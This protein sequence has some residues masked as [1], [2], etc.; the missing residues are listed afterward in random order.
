M[1]RQRRGAGNRFVGWRRAKS[2]GP[3]GREFR[4]AIEPLEQRCVLAATVVPYTSATVDPSDG[5]RLSVND[6]QPVVVA[7]EFATDG[8]FEGWTVAGANSSKVTGGL[9]TA[10]A[11]VVGTPVSLT[12]SAIASAPFL[13]YGFYDYI[14]LRMQ[15]PV[16]L[17]SDI[18]FNFSTSTQA[19]FSSARSFTIP[20]AQVA[21]DGQ[22]H[23]YRINVG[24]AVWWKDTLAGLQISIPTTTAGQSESIDY[25]EVG[26]LP[27]S[28]LAVA[29]LTKVQYPG[30]PLDPNNTVKVQTANIQSVQSKHFIF[31]Y[32]SVDAGANPGNFTN[33]ATVAHNELQILEQSVRIYTQV[34]GFKDVFSWAQNQ[35]GDSTRYKLNVTS[36]YAG[37]FS[38]GWWLNVDTSGG[39]NTTVNGNSLTETPGSP[40]PHEYGHVTDS[41]N[42]NYLAGGHFESH[43]NWYRE[44]WV[45]WYAPMF[46]AQGVTPSNYT[47]I[48]QQY[49]NLHV[50]NARLIYNDMR[51]YTPLQYY[52]DSMGL[53]PTLV[54]KLWS[55]GGTNLTIFN[56]LANLLPAG[57]SIKDVAAKLMAYWPTLDF[58]VRSSM[59]SAIF[60]S[61]SAQTAA[62]AQANF[63]YQSTSYLIPDADD[64]GYTVPLER[65]PEKYAYM[66][67][68]LVPS[69]GSTSVTVTV[70]GLPSTDS[71]ADWRYVLVDLANFG[72]TNP[73]VI[74]YSS[75]FANGAAATFN[76]AS[77]TDT[78]VLVVTATPSNTVLDLTSY[79]NTARSNQAS[80]RLTYPYQ[81]FVTGATPASGT[82]ARIAYPRS[83]SGSFHIN[84]DGSTGGWVD[85]SASVAATVYVAPGAEVLRNAIVSGSARIEDFAVV[86]DNARVSGSAIISGYAVV[87]GSA[88]ISGSA[89]VEDHAMVGSGGNVQGN[90]VVEQDAYL[91]AF[92]GQSVTVTNNAVVRGVATPTGGTLSGTA[93]IDYDYTSDFSLSNGVNDNNHPF[94]EPYG[95]YYS[96]TQAKPNGLIASYGINETSGNQL[97]DEFGALNAL[98]RGTPSRVA[99]ATMNAPVLSL[100]GSTQYAV[101]DRS[102]ADLADGTYSLWAN[103][104]SSTADQPLLYLGSSANTYLKLVARDANGFAHL[105]ISMNGTVQQLVS[106]VAVPL[107]SWTNIAI[108]FSG[109]QAKFYI[110]GA[111]AGTAA[112]SF[113]PTD[114]LTT[115]AFQMPTSLF[116]G[117]DASGNFFA[118][119]LTDIRFYNVALTQAE[120]KNEMARSGPRIGEFFATATMD[121]NGT[122]TM[123]ESGVHNGT[124]RTLQAWVYPRS[125]AAGYTAILDSYDERG[126][127]NN[128]GNGF[129]LSGGVI[130]VRLDGVGLWNTGV[131]V[132]LNKWQQITVTISNGLAI[133]YVNGVQRGSRTYSTSVTAA[134][135]YHIGFYQTDTTPT[136]TGFFNGQLYDVRV[137]NAAVA[138]TGKLD[139]PPVAVNDTPTVPGG[140]STPI[141]VLANDSDPN[142]IVTLT[143]SQVTQPQHGAVSIPLGGANVVYTPTSGYSGSDSFTYTATD[144]F[145]STA[146]A[147]VNLT[148]AISLASISISP[149]SAS[150]AGGDTQQFTATGYD[151]AGMPMNP[152]PTFTWSIV[153]GAGAVTPSGGTNAS[154]QF[155]AGSNTETVVIQV[156][157]G[158]VSST[159]NVNVTSSVAPAITNAANAS[160]T[161]VTG[162]TTNL[163]VL[164]A[165]A[166]GDGSLTYSWSTL[167]A[168]PAAVQFSASGT[169]GA[170]NTIA[171]FSKA[172]NYDFQVKVT[173]PSGFYATSN[174]SVQVVQTATGVSVSPASTAIA[175][176]TTKLFTASNLDQFGSVMPGTPSV[177]WSIVSGGGSINSACLFSAGRTAGPVTIRATAAGGAFGTAN[178]TV[179]YEELAWYQ[180][181]ASG[182][183]L[184]DS[185]GNGKTATLTGT[186]NTNYNFTVGV[187]GTALH[188][189]TAGTP[190]AEYATLP[191]GIVSTLN[192]FTIATW[193]KID[194]L[195]TW[196]RIFDFGTGTTAN[197][198]LTPRAN[199]VGGPLRFA[200]TTGGNGAEQQINGPTLSAGVWYH[201]A[202]TLSGTTATM[203]VNG[204]AVATNTSMSTTPAAMGNTNLNY[205]GKSQYGDPGFQGSIEDF[206]IFGRALSAT[207][208]LHLVYPTIV[209][210]PTAAAPNPVVTPT[211]NLSVFGADV[212]A[213]ESA[214]IYTSAVVGTPPAPV[215]FF[216]NGT[217]AAKNTIVTFTQPGTYNFQVTLVNPAAGFSTV[218]NTLSVIVGTIRYSGDFTLNSQLGADDLPAMLSALTDLTGFQAQHGLSNAEMLAIGDLN[219]D[220]RVSNA[221]I[222]SLLDRLIQAQG[223]GSGSGS[224]ANE[225]GTAATTTALPTSTPRFL[226]T[227][228]V[229][230]TSGPPIPIRVFQT[231]QAMPPITLPLTL[232]TAES[233]QIPP[234]RR[235][236]SVSGGVVNPKAVDAVFALQWQKIFVRG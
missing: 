183:T 198:F 31:Y 214:L 233:E 141:N 3:F 190:A 109:G 206:R 160:P 36:W 66:T 193:V 24:K 76:I 172:G 87:W 125:N 199:G 147:T 163:S 100:N 153:S 201:I 19:G 44:Q 144:G 217:N 65:A 157:S 235:R 170:K 185:S 94:D 204:V 166:A 95:V 119:K 176:N 122:S 203:Y 91:P 92:L 17:S 123:A 192:D 112:V 50:D 150:L 159:V 136:R 61:N 69:A 6:E 1:P 167:G 59:Q 129:G 226:A 37:Y 162:T 149:S 161:P 156:S 89:R 74:S 143:V 223:S 215:T 2:A 196:S 152:Q 218:S 118:G 32:D 114:V 155:T 115:G 232:P 194:T 132:T 124:T 28:T 164:A 225:S 189:V 5:L 131:S 7:G 105:T 84:P 51:V 158:T 135:N 182:T 4:F 43:A 127:G 140:L 175:A 212:T 179:S 18:T 34:L 71:G 138:P 30:G 110:N 62:E 22:F 103:P 220:G 139:L 180:A 77:A 227:P 29:P 11:N 54:A 72:T 113:R 96:V 177:T 42:G 16:G 195:A 82:A 98:L 168:P 108:T 151:Q 64:S 187:D 145:G 213:G 10:T 128:R 104:S 137:Y 79:D 8:N 191:T 221:D 178:V 49:S 171:T 188:L 116:L 47:P 148:V 25:I 236:A 14:Q 146:T 75:A 70:N 205:L 35:F 210:P 99:D 88:N 53:D 216:T 52:A 228:T 85:S 219:G 27:N 202:I 106:T 231:V 209:N 97:F 40:L 107:N 20:A 67:H 102:L 41:Q 222:Q 186:L 197:M 15:L 45:N 63:F 181:N 211:T 93:I 229:S 55:Q 234:L 117:H 73:T 38:G 133:L 58:P 224:D 81:V 12:R 165:D 86:S 48:A 208:I 120:V 101:L 169:N 68:V 130:N 174:V 154:V 90:A 56:K 184:T 78:V 111:A 142:P 9:V 80:M 134:K 57:V 126:S 83:A 200:I 121:F 33:F 60:K 207:E 230:S 23:V 13:D 46:T 173:N 39:Q 26:D 21:T